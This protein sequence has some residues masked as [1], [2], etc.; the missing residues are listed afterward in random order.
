MAWGQPEAQQR[1]TGSAAAAA[2]WLQLPAI[3]TGAAVD[4]VGESYRQAALEEVGGGRTPF[5]VRHPV[6]T[7]VLVREP[8]NP[9][10]PNAVRVEAAGRHLAYL[11]RED[12]PRFH[13][14][15]EKLASKG[16][17]ASCRAQLIGG[18]A[19]GNGNDGSIGIRILTGR[20]PV[21]WNDR[22]H[23]L[24]DGPFHEHYEV[25]LLPAVSADMLPK[26]RALVAL[27]ETS[28]DALAVRHGE[29]WLGHITHRPDLVEFIRRVVA[30]GLP[31]TAR[32]RVHDGRLTVPFADQDAVMSRLMQYGIN[33]VRDLREQLVPNGWWV[34]QRCGRLWWDP[35][36]P[37]PGWMYQT[38]ED[39]PN[40]CPSCGSYAFTHPR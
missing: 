21:E 22:A 34:C 38:E 8:D 36:Q 35:R 37:E 31:A 6:I 3:N 32:V 16:M 25:R 10:D 30:A 9:H 11:S 29:T 7:A 28:A 18:W 40:I 19:S 23:F 26:D 27:V 15:I 13:G 12:A 33:R 17:K 4:A 14:V 20:R 5:G 2:S 39:G 24:P 1:A